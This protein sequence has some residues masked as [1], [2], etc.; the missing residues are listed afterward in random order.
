ME[1]RRI[2]SLDK[3]YRHGDLSV[4][5]QALDSV[6]TLF[7]AKNN[8]ETRLS[9]KL[10]STAKYIIVENASAFPQSGILK[11]GSEAIFYT[12]KIGNQFHLLQRKYASTWAA[13]TVVSLPV[14]AEH[15]NALKDAIIKIQNKIGLNENP[16]PQSLHGVL[17]TLEQRWLAPKAIFKAYPL[18]G[19]SPLTVR[20]Q[21]FSSGH[22]MHYLWDFGDGI[23]SS[24]KHP[25]HTY[26]G[27]GAYTVKL[28]MVSTTNAQVI[29]EKNDYIT[30]SSD[31]ISPFFYGRPLMGYSKATDSISPTNF[32]FVDQTDGNITERHWFFGDGTD[33][34]V[35]N[36]N[37]HSIKHTYNKPGDY[38]PT[39][40]VKY[41]DNKTS[42][43]NI[44]E[45]IGVL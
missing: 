30:V 3:N 35:S 23:T 39:L 11:V 24:E 5:P 28:N 10:T 32:T 31:L 36:P 7:E 22:G 29:T 2:T 14:M 43:A 26:I 38:K 44:V 42:R 18:V 21:N 15:H 34:I 13:G 4:F 12:K 19:P 37:I 8:L 16:D 33:A 9:H 25:L 6:F 17:R 27:E 41:A 20:F 1:K 45:G 40:M